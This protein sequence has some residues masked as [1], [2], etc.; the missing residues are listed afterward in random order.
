MPSTVSNPSSASRPARKAI[1]PWSLMLAQ[2]EANG[3]R[4]SSPLSATTV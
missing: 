3:S 2:P 4:P 1:E